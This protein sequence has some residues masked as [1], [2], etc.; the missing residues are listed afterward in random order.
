MLIVS[1]ISKSYGERILF[2]GLSFT[3]YARD[4]LGIV[5][6][7]GT[8]KTTLL[9]IIAGSCEY[10]SGEVHL[11]KGVT[12]GY[13]E[14]ELSF[15][16][17]HDLLTEV[18]N[19]RTDAE[20]IEHKRK[21]IH[22]SLMETDDP[23]KQE[24]LAHELSEIEAHYEHSGGYAVEYEAKKIL[25]GLGFKESDFSRPVDEFSGGWIM[26]IGLAKLLLC[27]PD[28][29]FLDEPTNHLDLDAVVWFEN[30]LRTYAGAIL[31]ISH[32]RTFLNR[33]TNKIISL[34][35]GMAK[36]YNGN[37]DEYCTV[38]EK[39]LA[40]LDSTIKNQERFIESETRFINRFRAKNTKASQVQS[41]LKRLEKMELVTSPAKAGSVKLSIKK[42]PRC[43]KT[44]LS[45]DRISFGYDS[46][47]IYRELSLNI[48]RGEKIALVGPNGSGKSTLL[49]LMAGELAP[50]SGSWLPGHNVIPSYYA[51]HQSDQLYEENTVIDEMK[52]A[53]N[54]EADERLR[55]ILGAFLFSGDDVFKKVSVLSGGEKSRL[56]LAKLFLRPANFILMDEP[57]NHLDIPSRDILAAAMTAYDGTLCLVTHDRKLIDS[58]ADRIYEV[59]HGVVSVYHGNYSDYREKKEK[60]KSVEQ[61][62]LS[63]SKSP[64]DTGTRKMADKERKRREGELRNLFYRK[65]KSLRNRIAAIEK[66]VGSAAARITDIESMLENPSSF[67]NREEFNRL[68]NEYDVLKQRRKALDDEWLELEIE[69]EAVKESVWDNGLS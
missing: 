12:I 26:R 46:T 9:D 3:L 1:N 37:Y 13:L 23:A 14:Q 49:K 27:E 16:D 25:A 24:A 69:M 33:I 67:G 54:D 64:Q 57:T 5:G 8:G 38:R 51:Q 39:E 65:S 68:L 53:A 18:V 21:I 66:E 11:Q 15:D 45:F 52:R 56:A 10:D 30:Y 28:L 47:P 50:D 2:S 40:T 4:R 7:N 36:L 60:D 42:P 29:L 20:S 19:S 63:S 61:S 22:D 44:V 41:R 6:A 55:T 59:I 48:V 17:R 62:F 32:D 31:I 35:M 43:G 58:V 34:E